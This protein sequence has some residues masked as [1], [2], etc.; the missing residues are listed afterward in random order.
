[1]KKLQFLGLIAVLS[2][3]V[4]AI[5]HA[6]YDVNVPRDDAPFV[7]NPSNTKESVLR[8]HQF[9][10]SS[11]KDPA[12]VGAY[13]EIHQGL[14]ESFAAGTPVIVDPA[15]RLERADGFSR[16][17]V[18]ELE[19]YVASP[20]MKARVVEGICDAG[21]YAKKNAGPFARF[22]G[23][24]TG[25]FSGLAVECSGKTSQWFGRGLTSVGGQIWNEG[26]VVWSDGFKTAK[27]LWDNKQEG[28]AIA[29]GLKTVALSGT[30]RVLG[31]LTAVSS[32]LVLE[33]FGYGVERAGQSLREYCS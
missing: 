15:E 25:W 27:G 33:K 26:G 4:S 18:S 30:L 3:G 29:E 1:M 16:V 13:A 19:D 31:G 14:R 12:D 22:L 32:F 17:Q 24:T 6:R 23:R 21:N 9:N 11:C 8:L 10:P 28:R 20:S 5:G 7:F 2:A